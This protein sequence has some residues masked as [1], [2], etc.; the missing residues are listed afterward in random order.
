MKGTL[1]MNDEALIENGYRRFSPS[2]LTDKGITDVFQKRFDDEKGI[3]YFI[4]IN[5][6]EILYHPTTN[7][8]LGPT[9]EFEVY[10]E[11]KNMSGAIRIMFYAGAKL[12]EV[13]EHIEKLFN[14]GNYNY[15]EEY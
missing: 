3:K 5:K 2:S 9:Y 12:E 1:F 11:P 6:W 4:T 14:T 15:Y 7:E 8:K 10:L 13:E